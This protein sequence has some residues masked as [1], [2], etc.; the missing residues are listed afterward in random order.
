MRLVLYFDYDPKYEMLVREHIVYMQE[1]LKDD[2]FYILESSIYMR[3][4]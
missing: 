4:C 3:S 2:S 1:R